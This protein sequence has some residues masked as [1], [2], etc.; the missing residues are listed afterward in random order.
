LHRLS[1]DLE[2]AIQYTRRG[3]SFNLEDQEGH[4][5]QLDIL[6]VL[7]GKRHL[8]TKATIDLEETIH[9]TREAFNKTPNGHTYR[10]RVLNNRGDKLGNLYKR[11][12]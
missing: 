10:A 5:V 2:E 12:A 1:G 6:E 8:A 11:T 3:L 9:F 7:F 4:I